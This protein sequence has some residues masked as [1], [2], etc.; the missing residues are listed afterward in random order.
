MGYFRLGTK[1]KNA[2]LV[3]KNLSYAIEFYQEAMPLIG[4][5]FS[6]IFSLQL[7]KNFSRAQNQLAD[8]YFL[9]GK[10]SFA[11]MYYT[12]VIQTC[13]KCILCSD[14]SISSDESS[15]FESSHSS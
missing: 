4:S 15:S 13:K 5:D 3:L 2:E 1:E 6:N 7:V 12:E 9:Q 10:E 14:D 11:I 8:H